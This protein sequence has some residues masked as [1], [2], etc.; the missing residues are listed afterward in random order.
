[1]ALELE[2]YGVEDLSTKKGLIPR[3]TSPT[4]LEEL[5]GPGAGSFQVRPEIA[6][7]PDSAGLFAWR[8]VVKV[9]DTQTKKCL[10][11]FVI[12]NK[13]EVFVD[14]AEEGGRYVEVSGEGLRTWFHDAG[15]Y[16]MGGLNQYSADTRVFSFAS[17]QGAWYNPAQW[18]NPVNLYKVQAAGNRWG[19]APA[20]WPDEPNAYW[21]WDRSVATIETFP[22][23]KV[24]FRREFTLAAN[25]SCSLFIAA[26]NNYNV[27]VDAQQIAS[28][29]G[30]V[31]SN[32]QETQRLDFNLGPGSHILAVEVENTGGPAGLLAALRS[33][34]D[35]NSPTTASTIFKTGDATGWKILPYPT[36]LPGWT[37]GMIL[38]KLLDEAETRGVKFPSVVQPTFTDNF[39]SNGVAWNDAQAWEFDVGAEY[40]EVIDKIEELNADIWINPETFE[41]NAVKK[42]GTDRTVPIGNDD[43][44]QL[45][46]GRNVTE[47]SSEGNSDMKNAL[48]L[49]TADGWFEKQ[50]TGPGAATYGRMEAQTAT[51]AGKEFSDTV[52]SY[53]FQIHDQ[54]KDSVTYTFLPTNDIMP[55][56][57][58]FVG[59]MVLAPDSDWT[60][61]PQRVSSLSATEDSAGN[62]I[63]A[64]EF[65][66]IIADKIDRLEKRLDNL[67]NGA[68]PTVQ[69]SSSNVT[70]ITGGA[71]KTFNAQS[72]TSGGTNPG[73][74]GSVTP[75]AVPINLTG[76]A[77]GYFAP[78]GTPK[79]R[80]RL[81]WNAVTADT[82][83]AAL[84]VD[85]YD[86][87]ARKNR[88]LAQRT[89]TNLHTNPSFETSVSDAAGNAATATQS[90]TWAQFGTRSL[91][92][93]PSTASVSSYATLGG[94]PG[95]LRSGLAAGNWYNVSAYLRLSATQS[96]TIDPNARTLAVIYRDVNGNLQQYVSKQIPNVAN[97]T[98]RASLA[99]YI[100][101]GA[102]EAWIRVYNGTSTA[103][104]VDLFV[105]A[106]QVTL[107]TTLHSYIDGAQTSDSVRT[108][109]WTGTAHA[110][111]SSRVDTDV[112]MFVGSVATNAINLDGILPGDQWTV[113]VAAVAGVMSGRSSEINVTAAFPDTQ[114]GIPTDPVVQSA[115]GLVSV[116][117]DGLL[118]GTAPDLTFDSVF[119]AIG[120][121]VADTF[122]PV[123][124]A[125]KQ[126][127]DIIV[128][129]LVAGD[130]KY[131]QLIAVDKAGNLSGAS[132]PIPVTITAGAGGS[133]T[134]P[135]LPVGAITPYAGAS[136]P[137]GFLMADG[138]AVSRTQ[139]SDLFSVIGTAYGAGDGST[140][141]NLPNMKGSIPVGLDTSQTEFNSLGKVGGSKTNTHN[142]YVGLA[143]DGSGMFVTQTAQLPRSRVV[144]KP[145]L[146]PF[147]G[148]SSNTTT[149]EDSTYD[150][151]ISVLS[152][153]VTV[154]YV[155]RYVV[156][157]DTGGTSGRISY[158][159]IE[160]YYSNGK[161][162]VIF[163][164]DT[165]LSGPYQWLPPYIPVA[166]DRVALAKDPGGSY[167]ILGKGQSQ[168]SFSNRIYL[169]LNSDWRAYSG[170]W[171]PFSISKS[172]HGLVTMEGLIN[173]GPSSNT[174]TPGE[175]IATL[176]PGFRPDYDIIRSIYAYQGST[177]DAARELII[178]TNGDVILGPS[179]SGGLSGNFLSLSGVYFFA[180]G[181][182]DWKVVGV[183]SGYAY[184]SNIS[185]Y[186][187]GS[188]LNYG[189][190]RI[191]QEPTS[192]IVWVDG[193]VQKNSGNFASND[194]L[195]SFPTAL[196]ADFQYIFPCA[197]GPNGNLI[198]EYRVN[199]STSGASIFYPPLGLAFSQRLPLHAWWRPAAGNALA[200]ANL[201]GANSW[202]NYDNGVTY[203]PV[204]YA[205]MGSV[206]LMR[207]L[208]KSGT[209]PATMTPVLNAPGL[210]IPNSGGSAQ[211][212]L[213]LAIA[214]DNIA[215][216]DHR[217]Q[218]NGALAALLGS[219]AWFAVDGMAFSPTS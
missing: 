153:Y 125:L 116:H 182:A 48:I 82:S 36:T 70:P 212:A 214:A 135:P 209:V 118:S 114:L 11:A 187:D 204:S 205:R 2:V 128:P 158:G 34:G 195:V 145:R 188:G 203:C 97:T 111:T 134:S 68:S 206:T 170:D 115:F 133:L 178:R 74:G 159:T 186:T 216:L 196:A 208:M 184:G 176:P 77:V 41:L 5:R 19:T 103:N 179:M 85:H 143:N 78:D 148:A 3:R 168:I 120:A 30:A 27:Y 31:L 17:E 18:V 60:Y 96:G 219:N 163:D 141:F 93:S 90:S 197:A 6:N 53:I 119:A 193:V 10:G 138:S 63:Y 177:T 26:D 28:N 75:P 47:G 109:A 40:S 185:A 149:R 160:P 139:Y 108:Y 132:Q 137:A 130:T 129:N 61:S 50:S 194:T 24:Y 202:F 87:W 46:V 155:I 94:G 20:N 55:W 140:T 15:V 210:S 152:P 112:N 16:P 21:I 13:S 215:R 72:G 42:R 165:G 126:A 99:V 101:A 95:G 8:N 207:G 35:P 189:P 4:I 200:F 91:K 12:Q 142:H 117:W 100:P 80:F 86:V 107:G 136:A 105:D 110:S 9:R 56:D 162:S 22:V 213:H 23:G 104:P 198:A 71:G 122:V 29:G 151:T 121:S 76:D 49:K 154:N 192:G 106:V 157:Q 62:V 89:I 113:S 161:P 166:G 190:L 169:P 69:G 123:G 14:S 211:G 37:T 52:A 83:G 51:D 44:V 156:G 181:Y 172:E 171:N 146:Q 167:V 150:E 127:G 32:F 64:A 173:K 65:G 180:A 7:D 25:T 88:T 39:D 191:Y 33:N 67:S 144:T 183:D 84:T 201:T 1:M 147:S 102:T 81:R 43:A 57:K 199:K 124:Q 54:P 79:S 131:F 174:W 98:Y 92:V 175:V 38:L 217:P 45:R 164:G 58:V 66:T 218:G 59:D 73:G